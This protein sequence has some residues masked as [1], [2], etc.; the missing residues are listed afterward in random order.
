MLDK[1]G[2]G[3]AYSFFAIPTAFAKLPQSAWFL[4]QW[5]QPTCLNPADE[6]QNSPTTYDNLYGNA[7]YTWSQPSATTSLSIYRNTTARGGGDVFQLT[8]GD[9]ALPPSNELLGEADIFLSSPRIPATEDNLSHPITLTL[10]A[11]ITQ[12]DRD[13]ASAQIAQLYG[14]SNVV[15]STLDLGFSIKYNGAGNLGI[16]TAFVS[17]FPWASNSMLNWGHETPPISSKNPS[18]IIANY[19]LGNDAAL[20]TLP[21]DANA[22]PQSLT[23]NL[24]KYVYKT[25]QVAFAEFTPAQQ[26]DLLNLANWSVG[27]TYIGLATHNKPIPNPVNGQQTIE[28]GSI[29]AAV[30]L[31]NISLTSDLNATYNPASPPGS[32]A[33]IDT[34]PQ[35]LFF[36]ATVSPTG[37]AI[38]FTSVDGGI[39]TGSIPGIQDEY[40]YNGYDNVAL[41]APTGANWDFG[42][43]FGQTTLSAASGG[44]IFEASSQSSFISIGGGNASINAHGNDAITVTASSLSGIDLFP[45]AGSPTIS[46]AG[47]AAIAVMPGTGR[48]DF[49]N[50]SSAA[51]TVFAG[52]IATVF[53]GA[54]GGY[55]VG[56][57]AGANALTGGSGAVTLVS[58]GAGD[59]LQA[60][61]NAGINALFARNAADTLGASPSTSSNLFYLGPNASGLVSSAGSGTQ[62]FYLESADQSSTITGSTAAGALNFYDIVGDT[63]SGHSDYTITDFGASNS[64]IMLSN[65][66]ADGASSA[67]IS[68]IGPM[69]GGGISITLTDQ[70]QISLPGFNPAAL[71]F[72]TVRNGVLAIW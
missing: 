40:F 43:G 50:A 58:G 8:D 26:A 37:A 54:G 68:Q 52:G 33:A 45:G 65:R 9:T 16:Y 57:S 39:Y 38:A 69:A 56:G 66:W 35:M 55:F 17:I 5:N 47:S 2:T 12:L 1:F 27:G 72:A 31:S 59:D 4:A 63:A 28:A 6:S 20:P 29:S 24:N 19:L 42:G 48:L 41:A 36:D 51:A 14:Y 71:H 11:K 49:I 32:I 30:Q 3:T 46:A 67:A 70:T 60:N 25:L 53:A 34:N 61:A 18:T 21:A 62:S 7:L 44:Y 64:Y 22:A 10:D 13:F 15:Y 23:Y